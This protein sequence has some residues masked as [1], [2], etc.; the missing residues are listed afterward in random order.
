MRHRVQADCTHDPRHR[1]AAGIVPV[2]EGVL[3]GGGDM[4][5]QMFLDPVRF[6][7]C[8]RCRMFVYFPLCLEQTYQSL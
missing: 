2:R 6:E 8:G 5:V 4:R 3:V 7:V 1:V